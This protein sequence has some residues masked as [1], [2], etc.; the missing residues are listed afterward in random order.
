MPH[1]IAS[2]PRA[3][4]VALVAV[5]ATLVILPARADEHQ[6]GNG[7]DW[8]VFVT[9]DARVHSSSDLAPQSNYDYLS[10][11]VLYSHSDGRFRMLAE[12]YVAPDELD[13]ERL[14]MGWEFGE[15]TL[16]W[17]GRFH[18]PSS[19]WNTEH[20]HGQYLQT[21][22]TRPNI[23]HWEDEGGLVPQHITGALLETRGALGD[24]GGLT[25]AAGG[26]AAPV[27]VDGAMRP[28]GLFRPNVGGYRPSWSARV[29]FLP[30]LLGDE[31][32][33]LVLAHHE[34]NVRDPTVAALLSAN[35]VELDVVGAF[36][37]LD[38]RNWRLQATWYDIGVALDSGQQTRHER[39][40]AGYLQVERSLPHAL[41][42]YGR[43]ESS[44]NAGNST[45]VTFQRRE[46]ELRRGL[47]GLRWD[48]ARSQALTL[49]A[50]HATTLAVPFNELRL[51]WSGVLP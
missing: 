38:R 9:G 21:A 5:V 2:H 4:V 44:D 41:T 33:G 45:Y 16:A 20:H 22:I 17:I 35:D 49:E 8:L 39:F 32:M 47:V 11:D 3:G 46:F 42:A 28:L 51:Q 26:G 50:T 12:T 13:V 30:E 25:L 27:I 1:P 10:A 19:A 7:S 31:S 23:E 15:N 43:V 6:H 48:L 40:G 18:Q 36:V 24:K 37:K 14:Q 34:L 29:S